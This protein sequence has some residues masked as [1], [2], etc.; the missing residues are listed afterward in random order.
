MPPITPEQMQEASRR[1]DKLT[2]NLEDS[3]FEDICRR[4]SKTSKV[5]DTAEFQLRRLKEMGYANDFIEK[6]VAEY[7]K[8]SESEIQRLF[9]ETAQVSEDFYADYYTKT[10]KSYTPLEKNE[11]MQQLITAEIDQTKGELVNLTQSM[12]F[13]VRQADGSTA[14]TGIAKTYQSVLDLAQMQVAT[15]VFD[16]NTAIRNAVVSLS[17]SGL[18][19][20]DYASGHRNRADVAVRR[21]VL[22]GLSQMTGEIAKRNAEAL[23]TDIVEVTAHAGARPSHAE[24]QGKWYSLSGKSKEYP[25]LEEATGYGRGDGLKGWNCRHDFY[26]VIPGISERTYTDEELANIDPEPIEY[27]GKTLT[28][29]ECTQ[30]QRQMETAMRRTKRQIIGAKASEDDDMFTAKSVLLRRQREEYENFSKAAGL[31]T[32]NERTRVYGFDRSVSAKASWAVRKA[33]KALDNS[34]NSGIMKS[35][36]QSELGLLKQKLQSDSR[37]TKEYYNC[38]K[39]KFSQGSDIAKKAFNKYVPAD[40]VADSAYTGTPH[41]N[42]DTQKISMSYVADLNNPRGNGATWFHEHGH[43]I[44]NIAGNMS[45]DNKF[46]ELLYQD[47]RSYMDSYGKSNNLKTFDKVQ[48]AISNDLNS[49]RKHS[50]VSD[51]LEGLSRGNIKGIAG[52]GANYWAENSNAVN[53]E[54]FAHMFESQFDSTRYTE[55]KKYFPNALKYF[56]NSLKEAVK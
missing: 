13:A 23:D 45:C 48:R 9:Y 38:I 56:E 34:K 7:T 36:Q 49:M 55:M 27:N 28:Y 43:L 6:T 52:H 53:T 16:Y 32:Q 22:T 29:Y 37:I 31:L 47:Y 46:R 39:N 50:A 40:S 21:A 17:D 20:V 35:E 12:G 42:M 2:Q 11:Y 33:E 26:P 44:D 54:A 51:I 30:K 19:F 10:G 3:I 5:T 15:G 24:W 8:K 1:L 4:I 18:Q 41:Y 25:S 14:F